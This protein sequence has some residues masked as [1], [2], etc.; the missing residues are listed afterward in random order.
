RPAPAPPL[1]LAPR[2]AARPA[3]APPPPPP[4]VLAA[5]LGAVAPPPRALAPGLEALRRGDLED[6]VAL[7][8]GRGEG[9]TPAGDD[10]LAG[11]AARCRVRLSRL[12]AGRASP[13][14]L[15][16]LR[17]AER[18]ELPDVVAR[19]LGA[20]DPDTARRRARAL[21]RWGSSSGAA[22]LWGIASA[23]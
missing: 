14:G 19:V 22:M 7:L 10:V 17:C 4:A 2:G 5:A 1:A 20:R 9:L 15:A 21:S 18:G 11:Y 3:P 8:A 13:L 12:A 23:T 6:A 16:Y